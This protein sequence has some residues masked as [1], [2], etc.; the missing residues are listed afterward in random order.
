MAIYKNKLQEIIDK[1]LPFK[2]R[3]QSM[4]KSILPYSY[5]AEYLINIPKLGKWEKK[6]HPEKVVKNRFLLYDYLN[7]EIIKNEKISYLEFGVFEGLTINYWSKIN[8]NPK[9]RFVGFDTFTGLPE[10]WVASPLAT[11]DNSEYNANG[12]I[13]KVSDKRISF[14]KGYFQKT[15]GNFVD[16]S[17]LTSRLVIHSDSD[18]YSSTL[19]VLSKLDDYMAPG[20]IVIFDEFNSVLNEFRA[21]DDYTSSYMRDF[22][23][24]CSTPNLVQVAI[25]FV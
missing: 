25:E 12:V 20:T 10:D 23:I 19:F 16:K 17:N 9:S 11:H 6:Y 15:L 3:R 4:L 13:P 21:F 1:I 5:M 8:N 22:K 18:L 14:I 7:K 24:I 2:N